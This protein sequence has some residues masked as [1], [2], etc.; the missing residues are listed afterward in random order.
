M[1]KVLTADRTCLQTSGMRQKP[2]LDFKM[3]KKLRQVPCL[4]RKDSQTPQ[5]VDTVLL[6]IPNQQTL[7][8][9]IFQRVIVTKTLLY[10]P[11]SVVSILRHYTR[12]ESY[13]EEVVNVRSGR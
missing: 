9:A 2:L 10:P 4:N 6:Y 7:V 12:K 1:S 5:V 8:A 11:I 13:A 3:P